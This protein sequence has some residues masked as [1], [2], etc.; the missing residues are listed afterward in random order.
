MVS[1]RVFDHPPLPLSHLLSLLHR[2]Y[3]VFL[4]LVFLSFFFHLFSFSLP[5]PLLPHHHV[6][7]AELML[8]NVI[9][10]IINNLFIIT[11]QRRRNVLTNLW[12]YLFI[13][14]PITFIIIIFFIVIRKFSVNSF[15]HLSILVLHAGSGAGLL[16]T[17]G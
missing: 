3:F 5:L 13:I 10:M 14:I 4:Y 17:S 9:S 16:F 1:P 11:A 12:S 8:V 15:G 7:V 6:H 2:Q